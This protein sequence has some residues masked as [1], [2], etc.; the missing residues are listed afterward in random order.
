AMSQTASPSLD[1]IGAYFIDYWRWTS[2]VSALKPDEESGGEFDHETEEETPTELDT[3]NSSGGFVLIGPDKLSLLYPGIN[4][5]DH[6]VG[7]VQAN[8]PAPSENL[9][10]YFEIYAKNA[11]SKGNIAIGFTTSSFKLRRQPGW[12]P[13]SIGYHGHDGLLYHGHGKGEA[14]GPT[15][16][17][18]DTV[19]C[20]INNSTQE[21]FFTKNGAIVGSVYKEVKGELFPTVAVHSQNEE[22]SVNFGKDPFVFDIKAYEAEQRAK[23]Q[24]EIDNVTI[25]QESSYRIVQKYLQ[26]YGYE[27]TLKMFDISGKSNVPPVS[28]VPEDGLNDQYGTYALNE[29]RTL[30]QLIRS[31]KIQ[32]ALFAIQQLY[33]DILQDGTSAIC[34]LLHC[35]H[36]IELV[37]EGKLEDSISYGQREFDKF[38][39]HAGCDLVKDCATLLAYE[40]PSKSCVGYLLRDSQRELVA[41]A[42]NATIL[43][44]NPDVKVSGGYGLCSSLERLIRQVTACS[45]EKRH[46]NSD[47]GEVFHL[48]RILESGK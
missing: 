16:T 31:G 19:G 11:G 17:T 33:H 23:D 7:V 32:E 36:F 3:V 45:V 25:P 28:L 8:R 29:R 15:F 40:Q 42:V 44:T 14:F 2:K 41:D 21:F 12:E 39:N 20:G 9:L 1:A 22:V 38:K 18:G 24:S 34:L 37:R 4:H 43:L 5:H 30:R 26:H 35:Q 27:E 6:D 46:L 47:Q 10:Y 48:R 13:N